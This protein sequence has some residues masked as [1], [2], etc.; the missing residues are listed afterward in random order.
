MT[1]LASQPPLSEDLQREFAGK[2]VIVHHGEVVEAADTYD[3]LVDGVDVDER[4][5]IYR[6]PPASTLFY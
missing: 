6:V 1:R 4:D 2:W 3:D 5:A